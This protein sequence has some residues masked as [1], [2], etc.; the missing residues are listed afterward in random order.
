MVQNIKENERKIKKLTS[1][2]PLEIK[3]EFET[4]KILIEQTDKS[5]I[6]FIIYNKHHIRQKIAAIFQEKY[7]FHLVNVELTSKNK[8]PLTFIRISPLVS[9]TSAGSIIPS[10][11][12]RG[13]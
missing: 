12:M 3:E 11:N 1:D 6:A 9:A 2:L 10:V 5:I 7:S 8:T 13:C 4:L